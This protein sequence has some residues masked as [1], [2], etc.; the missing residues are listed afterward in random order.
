VKIQSLRKKITINFSAS[1]ILLLIFC[2]IIG[3]IFYEKNT[4]EDKVAVIKKEAAQIRVKANALEVSTI[5]VKKYRELWKT[6]TDNKKNTNGIK[7]NEVNSQLTLIADKY[8]ILN[9][10]I[11]I[12]LPEFAKD[13]QFKRSTI[14]I[15]MTTANLTFTALNDVKAISFVNEFINSLPGYPVITN[16]EIKK[17]KSYTTQDLIDITSGKGTGAISGKVDF[18]WYAYKEKS[19][20]DDKIMAEEAANSKNSKSAGRP[21]AKNL[22]R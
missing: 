3:Y 10:S 21:N 16:F 19:P 11:K 18:I 2:S 20:D 1:A 13:P 9:S 5:E 15:M 6:L 8:N 22:T 12:V 7:M 4:V 14:T 17:S